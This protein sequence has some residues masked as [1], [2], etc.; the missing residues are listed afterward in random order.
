LCSVLLYLFFWA[1]TAFGI[2]L[3]LCDDGF[4]SPPRKGSFCSIFKIMDGIVLVPVLPTP[5]NTTSS[6]ASCVLHS[7]CSYHSLFLPLSLSKVIKVLVQVH[8]RCPP[9]HRMISRPLILSRCSTSLFSFLVPQSH[10][11]SYSRAYRSLL[12][13]KM[14]D[15]SPFFG[16]GLE[17]L[18]STRTPSS[19]LYFLPVYPLKCTPR[20]TT[21]LS[22]SSTCSPEI[23]PFL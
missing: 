15:I 19:S 2:L 1:Q 6:A 21:P 18:T 11:A 8:A 7:L 5:Y 14:K 17:R 3:S 20:D 4:L 13:Y 16:H 23:P 9:D 12:I 22:S 10:L